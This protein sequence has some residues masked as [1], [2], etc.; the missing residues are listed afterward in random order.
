M[1]AKLLNISWHGFA[2]DIEVHGKGHE[3]H[4][5]FN[6][7]ERNVPALHASHSGGLGQ[8]RPGVIEQQ[9]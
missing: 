9:R 1:I 4:R 7:T 2:L 3:F 6:V 8:P 5:E